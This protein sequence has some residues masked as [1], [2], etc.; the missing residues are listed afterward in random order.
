VNH[1]GNR[2]AKAKPALNAEISGGVQC[3][4]DLPRATA[5]IRAAEFGRHRLITRGEAECECQGLRKAKE[6]VFGNEAGD[7]TLKGS[8]RCRTM[9]AL[10]EEQIAQKNTQDDR[11]GFA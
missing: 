10:Q 3:T 4:D 11:K 5:H 7:R 6:K 8:K 2:R 9:T 1:K